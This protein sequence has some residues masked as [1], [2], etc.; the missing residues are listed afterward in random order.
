MRG[1]RSSIQSKN[2]LI[3]ADFGTW[4]AESASLRAFGSS[5]R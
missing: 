5:K 2:G 4:M 1:G 3:T